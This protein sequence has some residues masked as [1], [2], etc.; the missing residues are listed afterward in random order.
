ME[1]IFGIIVLI[2]VVIAPGVL[3]VLLA[4]F[5]EKSRRAERDA[6]RF[7]RRGFEVKQTAGGESP[8]LREKEYDHG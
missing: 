3:L 7:Y 2:L 5:G 8:V 1:I 4:Y 6:D